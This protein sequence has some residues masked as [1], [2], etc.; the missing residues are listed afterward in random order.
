MT[1]LLIAA[2]AFVGTHF[3]MSHPLRAPMVRLLGNF[4]FL[5][6]YSAVSIVTLIWMIQAYNAVPPGEAA[7]A[8]GD[9]L[10]AVATVLMWFG[11]VLFVGS[12]LGN[13][14][15]P[16]VIAGEAGA[17]GPKGVF[18]I[19]RHPMMWGIALWGIVHIL[20]A[21][22]PANFVL[23]GA[24]IILAL[25]GS[26]LQDGKKKRL[27]GEAWRG[28]VARTSYFPFARGFAMPGATALIG[29]TLLWL[30]AMYG[31]RWFGIMGAGV[32]RW[33]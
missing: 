13:P 1:T 24:I 32:F 9:P 30:L 6:A 20:I 19:T 12:L 7:W 16:Y 8:V 28:W 23:N 3:L 2:I 17:R 22:R 18:A 4:F 15:F 29:G 10:W 5:G 21:P 33:V 11:S 27:L 14:A 25:V 26:A 31:H